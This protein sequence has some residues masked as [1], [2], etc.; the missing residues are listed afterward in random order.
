MQ[1]WQRRHARPE[2]FLRLRYRLRRSEHRGAT[3]SLLLSIEVRAW[4]NS[5]SLLCSALRLG[6]LALSRAQGFQ[7]L[8]LVT[9]TRL[10]HDNRRCCNSRDGDRDRQDRGIEGRVNQEHASCGRSKKQ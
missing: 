1:L 4:Q 3:W 10:L 5:I 7:R 6:A 9:R 2:T 8:T